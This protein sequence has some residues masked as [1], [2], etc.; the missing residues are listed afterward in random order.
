MAASFE[1]KKMSNRYM[2]KWTI[3]V[4]NAAL[5]SKKMFHKPTHQACGLKKLLSDLEI[6][7][8]KTILLKVFSALIRF[9]KYDAFIILSEYYSSIC[10]PFAEY[11]TSTC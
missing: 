3:C 11:Y 6:Y 1:F 7:Y 8:K 10:K 4:E 5:N 9:L 2:K